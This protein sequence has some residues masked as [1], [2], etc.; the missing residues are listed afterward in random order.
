MMQVEDVIVETF[1]EAQINSGQRW[2]ACQRAIT[3]DKPLTTP[4]QALLGN[5]SA[6]TDEEV[7]TERG[8]YTLS[9]CIQENT[10]GES[11][12]E[13]KTGA[14]RVKDPSCLSRTPGR[15]MKENQ[16]ADRCVT[17]CFV[18]VLS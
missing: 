10:A 2:I 17:F 7:E 1:V 3:S 15:R 9:R 5:V 4:A 18:L 16:E 6:E 13:T 8:N 14:F 11:R 12:K